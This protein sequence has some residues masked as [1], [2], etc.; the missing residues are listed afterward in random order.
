M[1]LFLYSV[2]F[3]D[4]LK[5]SD[6]NALKMYNK[7]DLD[8]LKTLGY[9]ETVISS[10]AKCNYLSQKFVDKIHL[11]YAEIIK[12]HP[13]YK[14]RIIESYND[15]KSIINTCHID[16]YEL[17][18][19]DDIL[20]RELGIFHDDPFRIYDEKQNNFYALHYD[21]LMDDIA[22]D[23]HIIMYLLDSNNTLD[24][25][26]NL[27]PRFLKSIRYVIWSLGNEIDSLTKIKIIQT[28][29]YRETM[30]EGFSLKKIGII[31]EQKKLIRRLNYAA[32][33]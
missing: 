31:H 13:D 20:R 33:K 32:S 10:L 11:L 5:T 30:L 12:K 3:G 7:I 28:L 29:K 21:E 26:I 9:F 15:M 17:Y 25:E 23:Y 1:E 2:L 6:D 22:F 18:L 16:G 4:M 27:D 8:A 19:Y 14:N 24:N